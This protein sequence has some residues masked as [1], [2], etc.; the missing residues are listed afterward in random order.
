[1]DVLLNAQGGCYFQ[2]S[3]TRRLRPDSLM[4]TPDLNRLALVPVVLGFVGHRALPPTD[5]PRLVS[6]L[7]SVFQRFRDACPH[8]PL[9]LLT[10]LAQ[11]G[12]LLA[13]GVAK[14]WGVE[15]RVALPMT[16]EAFLQSSSFDDNAAGKKAR[17]EARTLLDDKSLPRFTV[18]LPDKL[19]P[20][21]DAEWLA[22]ATTPAAVDAE[23][24]YRRH[25]AYANAAGYIVRHCHV[26]IVF[27]DGL[28]G[29]EGGTAEAVEFKLSAC[30]P[31][32]YPWR[33]SPRIGGDA[34]PVVV[35]RTRRSAQHPETGVSDVELRLPGRGMHLP[36]SGIDLEIEPCRRLFNRLQLAWGVDGADNSNRSQ[37][38]LEQLREICLNVDD[39]NRAVCEL[40][41][42]EVLTKTWDTLKN[43]AVS[44]AEEGMR[45][46]LHRICT[47]RDTAAQVASQM[48]AT[49]LTLQ[50]NL[51]AMLF[52]AVFFFHLYGHL[53]NTHALPVTYQPL[54]LVLFLIS[55]A[56]SLGIVLRVWFLRLDQRR[57][58]Y[59][60]LAETLRVRIFWAVAGSERSVADS[61]LGQLRG[62]M[63]WARRA[64]QSVSPPPRFWQEAFN[65]LSLHQQA[66]RMKAVTVL[67]VEMQK[68]Y[69]AASK[70]AHHSHATWLRRSAFTL[71][72]AGWCGAGLLLLQ[73]GWQTNDGGTVVNA[74]VTVPFTASAQLTGDAHYPDHTFLLAC[75][76]SIV[77]GG[78]L[79][80]WCERRSHEELARQYDR[81]EAVFVQ[82]IRGLNQA[83][84]M[85]NPDHVHSESDI[86]DARS[87]IET[88][89]REAI[90]D[91]AQWLVL[92]RSRLFELHLG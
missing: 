17:I 59:R 19:A 43:P 37:L 51:F 6:A 53:P 91:H 81:M 90:T 15:V 8:S 61:Y 4:T 40:E 89:G 42:E 72:F 50:L 85:D 29:N 54:W 58:D 30:P 62:P 27:W 12:D 84:K 14:K 13:I 24:A 80:G 48:E 16:E 31:A 26:L 87:I 71:T 67:W 77:V 70:H 2:L 45:I 74:A 66:Q 78:F 64:L 68:K 57:L 88:L 55:V 35:I 10:S 3:L 21:D 28:D 76:L 18:P 56:I 46:Q 41:A 49:L 73:L 34:G 75:A 7:E 47:L 60:A 25:Q 33:L 92:R 63:S 69:F 22:L 38:E 1:M 20:Q 83:L 36:W 86:A 23:L 11:G 52:L 44:G 5:A 65:L 79:N 32:T 9:V 82:G 39:F